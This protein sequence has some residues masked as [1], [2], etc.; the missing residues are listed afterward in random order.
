VRKRAR[1]GFFRGGEGEGAG[2]PGALGQEG[3]VGVELVQAGD[4]GLARQQAAH[5][6][7]LVEHRRL[8]GDGVAVPLDQL[9]ARRVGDGERQHPGARRLEVGQAEALAPGAEDVGVGR[10]IEGGEVGEGDAARGPHAE[11]LGEAHHPA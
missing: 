5:Q 7:E 11:V 3:R 4:R 2:A 8:G 6:A 10:G 1:T 9:A